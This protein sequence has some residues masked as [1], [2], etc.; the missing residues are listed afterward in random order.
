MPG[1]FRSVSTPSWS[2]KGLKNTGSENYGGPIVT[3][4][5]LVFIAATLYDNKFR[6][7][8]KSDRQARLGND[9]AVRGRCDAR[10]LPDQRASIHRRR[11]ER[12]GE[13]TDP[14]QHATPAARGEV[15]RIRAS[16]TTKARRNRDTG[17]RTP[18]EGAMKVL[19]FRKFAVTTASAIAFFCLSSV[20]VFAQTTGTVT[21]T[22][23][24]DQGGVIPGA[25]VTLISEARGTS[26]DAVTTVT[27]DFV[28]SN[29]TGDTYLV[30]VSMDGFKTVERRGIA[31]SPGDRV[32]VPAFSLQVGA[33]AETVTVALGDAPMIQSQTGERSFTVAQ[34]QA[35]NLPNTGRNFASFAALVPGTGCNHRVGR[36]QRRYQPSWRRHHELPAR[37][38]VE[39][40]SGWQWP[41]YS[42]QHGCYCR[43]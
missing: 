2:A 16:V 15:R 11:H 26:L 39:R 22:V 31:V 27:G 25:T 34:T 8:D 13:S 35:E 18:I 29:I 36:R 42:A 10:H 14:A 1:R 37:R 21:G 19:H 38:G 17:T 3:A 6:A 43:G 40:R 9:A 20:L 32:V 12:C 28:F 4:G 23:K 30:R 7:F 24:D 41:R 5:G 33:L